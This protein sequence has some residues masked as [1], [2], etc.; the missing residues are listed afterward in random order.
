MY[1]NVIKALYDKS[2]ARVILSGEKMKAFSSQEQ[3]KGVQSHHFI[4]HSTG[5]PG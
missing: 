3:D 4:Q 1:L 5:S 2:A